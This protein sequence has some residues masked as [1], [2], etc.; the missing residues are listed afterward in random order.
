MSTR[1]ANSMYLFRKCPTLYEMS[2]RAG[3]GQSIVIY[4]YVTECIEQIHV[5]C[6]CGIYKRIDSATNLPCFL[7]KGFETGLFSK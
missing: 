3:T 1:C 2:I 5:R 7:P 6:P 4:K